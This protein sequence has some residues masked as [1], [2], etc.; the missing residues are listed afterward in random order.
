MNNSGAPWLSVRRRV[1]NMNCTVRALLKTN[2]SVFQN[3]LTD[4]PIWPEQFWI[5]ATSIEV[6]THFVVSQLQNSRGVAIPTALLD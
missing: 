3:A 1:A 5:E 2:S 6:L 4:D